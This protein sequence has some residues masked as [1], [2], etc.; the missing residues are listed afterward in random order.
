MKIATKI[1]YYTLIIFLMAWILPSLYNFLF[2]QP[3]SIANY[4]YSPITKNFVH[5]EYTDGQSLYLDSENNHYNQDQYDSLLPVTY[6][7]IL[8]S[9]NKA[10][11]SLEG[12][13][14]DRM[15]IGMG[16]ASGSGG[17]RNIN[18]PHLGVKEIMESTKYRLALQD[19]TQV[20]RFTKNS[21]EI[22]N[23]RDNKIDT[24]KTRLFTDA[25]NEAGI[26]WPVLRS[27]GSPSSRKSYDFGYIILDSNNEVYHMMQ[28][29]GKPYVRKT[30]VTPDM[31][32]DLISMREPMNKEY[33]GYLLGNNSLSLLMANKDY[34]TTKLD[35]PLN[36]HK[37]N[38]WIM[39]NMLYWT[40]TVARDDSFDLYAINAHTYKTVLH[41]HHERPVMK[42]TKTLKWV[43]PFTVNFQRK[44][45]RW[46]YPSFANFSWYALILNLLLSGL[47]VFIQRKRK[48]TNY[49]MS[50]ITIFFGLFSFVPALF[51]KENS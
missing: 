16:M 3:N 23:K 34:T 17:P 25:F 35:F 42:Y 51:I 12:Y 32:I 7:F 28:V 24:L 29:H 26:Q 48:D 39:G 4:K 40:V 33:L 1:F 36:M 14:I 19:P 37:E 13:S 10:I 30:S 43:F 18:T 22:I 5:W 45:D 20:F 46:I 50:I 49:G 38:F 21:M 6:Y 9:K 41:E 2:Y 31:G 47:L 11:D 15:S 8:Q 44:T 27:S